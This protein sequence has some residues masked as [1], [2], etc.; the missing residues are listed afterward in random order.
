MKEYSNFKKINFYTF[1]ACTGWIRLAT[2][3]AVLDTGF[4]VWLFKSPY[5]LYF[6]KPFLIVQ[7]ALGLSFYL[8]IVVEM[9]FF[10]SKRRK[11]YLYIRDRLIAGE[12]IPKFVI[13]SF[14]VTRCERNVIHF[15]ERD[16]KVKLL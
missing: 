8:F 12:D 7:V 9:I 3:F 10:Y 6:T 11:S 2:L 14:G 1:W 16:F 4:S 13:Y 5:V 15:L